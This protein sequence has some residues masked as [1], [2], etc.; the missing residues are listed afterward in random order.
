[1]NKII[2]RCKEHP[3]SHR[4]RQTK[5]CDLQI[6]GYLEKTYI[7]VGAQD[8]F[9]VRERSRYASFP[10]M[11]EF[12]TFFALHRPLISTSNSRSTVNYPQND[13]LFF[14]PPE[15]NEIIRSQNLMQEQ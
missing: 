12:S 10:A 1:V 2:G 8:Q 7:P 4:Q 6:F 15:C 5:E 3:S 9:P 11:D 13:T 14:A